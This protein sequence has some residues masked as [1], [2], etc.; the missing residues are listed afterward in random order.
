MKK[1][2][3]VL[4]AVVIAL[5]VVA[6]L[7][8]PGEEQLLDDGGSRFCK[9]ALRMEAEWVYFTTTGKQT[10]RRV[11]WFPETLKSVGELK[12]EAFPS[13]GD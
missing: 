10:V 9:S 3:T 7:L 6:L 8:I 2:M 4:I 12:A 13:S 5:G 1:V 11:Y